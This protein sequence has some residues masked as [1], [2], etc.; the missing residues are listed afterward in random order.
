MERAKGCL[1]SNVDLSGCA[2]LSAMR[3]ELA[4]AIA[5]HVSSVESFVRSAEAVNAWHEKNRGDGKWSAAE[6]TEHLIAAYDILLAELR[7]EKGMEIKTSF[8]QRWLLRRTILPRILAGG[9]FPGNAR[10][11]RETRPVDRELSKESC[12]ALLRKKADEFETAAEAARA[13]SK[14]TH[15]YFGAAPVSEAVLMCARHVEH[16]RVHMLECAAERD[17]S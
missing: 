16:H 8:W 9:G 10:A 12:L 15:A 2:T 7:G 5:E 6:I 3:V 14:I 4:G 1:D 11:P 17:R 13:G